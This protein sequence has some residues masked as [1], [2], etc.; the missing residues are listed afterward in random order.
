MALAGCSFSA[1]TGSCS[2]H[3]TCDLL[4]EI[5]SIA[6]RYNIG[7]YVDLELKGTVTK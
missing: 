2:V 6:C 7:M 1:F 4:A 5:M 3:S